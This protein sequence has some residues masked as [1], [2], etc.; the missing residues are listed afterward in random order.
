MDVQSIKNIINILINPGDSLGQRVIVG[1]FWVVAFRTI[2]QGLNLIKLVVLARIL[3]P[4]D[5]GLMG[6][7]LLTMG[8]LETFSQTGFRQALIQRKE[9][10][11]VYLDGVWSF[12]VIRGFIL[13]AVLYLIAPMVARFFETPN[14]E[15]I[16]QVVGLAILI[17]SFTNIGVL[18]FLKELEFNR[19]FFYDITGTLVEFIVAVFAAIILRNVWALLFGFL[20]GT[21][22]RC[23]VSYFIHPY[24]PHFTLDLGNTKELWGFGKWI[25][26]SSILVFLITHGDDIFVG[27]LLGVT[28][29]GFYQ[30][31]YKI[32]NVPA[33]EVTHIISQVTFPTYSK[34]Q[35]N[36]PKFKDAYLK[37]LQIIAFLSFPAAGLIL[38][39]A[40]DFTRIFL[41]ESWMPMV[42]AIQVLA[43]WGVIR[44]VGASNGPVFYSIGRPEISAKLQLFQLILLMILIYPFSNRMGIVG[45]SLSVVIASL[46]PNLVAF[47]MVTRV[48]RFE[49]QS[50]VRL[51]AL[52]LVNTLIIVSIIFALKIYLSGETNILL[53]LMFIIISFLVY[54]G[55]SDLFNKYLNYEI[56]PLL[57]FMS[58]AIK[59]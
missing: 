27:K 42:P 48:I 15:P 41:G 18:Y 10:I 24:R 34:L 13:F 2:H 30:M 9:N 40:S 45:T 44:A 33:I 14:A 7:A 4:N 53:F 35:D 57:N 20:A 47:Y 43:L 39:L 28:A 50:L 19:Q 29:L 6:L 25:T 37:V 8:T 46:I 49:V 3:S 54:I 32:S 52:P 22:T 58:R 5:F 36:I 26:G 11:D 56:W 1:G 17:Q 31:A 23:L 12:M 51:I 21:V 16:I 55:V 59:K 38:V